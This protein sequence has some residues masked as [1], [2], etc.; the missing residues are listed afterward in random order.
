MRRHASVTL[1]I[2]R[3]IRRVVAHIV[4]LSLKVQDLRQ[5]QR[6]LIAVA[7]DLPL[8]NACLSLILF[9]ILANS[10]YPGSDALAWTSS[11]NRS[12]TCA[13]NLDAASGC[14]A[15]GLDVKDWAG[16]SCESTDPDD[17]RHLGGEPGFAL[18]RTAC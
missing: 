11:R 14:G 18:G 3:L 8:S 17:R 6:A 1:E 9:S 10:S 5:D 15:G 12:A 4:G 13:A 16:R 7:P 2:S